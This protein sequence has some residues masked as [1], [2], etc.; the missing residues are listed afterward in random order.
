MAACG[1][2]LLEW[3]GGGCVLLFDRTV[4]GKDGLCGEAL[5]ALDGTA[6]C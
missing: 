1:S 3:R 2:L 5:R 6:C 4:G